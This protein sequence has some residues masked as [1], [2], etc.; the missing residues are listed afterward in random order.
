MENFFRPEKLTQ[1]REL[2]MEEIA[3]RLDRNVFDVLLKQA[4]EKGLRPEP[5]QFYLD[6]FKYG[7]PPHGG[8]GLG[9]ARL[10]MVLL[11]LPNIREAVYL[12]RGP[13]RRARGG[14]QT[15][16]SPARASTRSTRSS[17]AASGPITTPR[18]EG[19]RPHRER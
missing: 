18:A 10:M 8:F 12:F 9:L 3:Y 14:Y 2:A 4:A 13:T 11:G 16:S 1:L 7:C 6:F 17:F 5:I 19:D 15:G